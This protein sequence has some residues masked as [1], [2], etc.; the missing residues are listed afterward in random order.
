[1]KLYYAPGTCALAC[2]IA[3][4]WAGADYE[5]VR[6]DYKSEEYQRINPLGAFLFGQADAYAPARPVDAALFSAAADGRI[7]LLPHA[8]LSAAHHSQL[9][10]IGEAVDGGYQLSV[11]KLLALLETAPNLDQPRTFLEQRNNGPLP[12]AVDDLLKRIEEDSRALQIQSKALIIRV[13]TAAAAEAVLNDPTAGKLVRRLDDRTLL[14]PANK[15]TALRNALRSLGY[16]LRG[17]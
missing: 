5:A 2:W 9:A 1:M 14:I 16:G 13:R 6:A 11:P 8:A 15:E 17:Q 12:P 4:E 7:T 10:Q 3:L